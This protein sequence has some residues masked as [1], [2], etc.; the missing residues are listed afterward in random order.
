MADTSMKPMGSMAITT[1]AHIEYRISYHLQ[2]AYNEIL[3]VGR[4]LNEAKD[5]GLVPHG[6]WEEWVRTTTNMSERQAQKLMQAARSIQAGS[7]MENLSISKIQ[8]ILALPEPEREEVAEK[9]QAEDMSL[10]E[11]QLEVAKR[12]ATQDKLHKVE[13]DLSTYTKQT[14]KEREQ[15][16]AEIK[17]LQ[18]IPIG[19]PESYGISPE[20]QARI[21]R[22]TAELEE[23]EAYAEAQAGLRQ[24]A[25]QQLLEAQSQAA[26][27]GVLRGSTDTR[28]SVED[29]AAAVRSFIGTAGMLPHMGETLRSAPELERQQYRQYIEMLAAWVEGA[30]NAMQEVDTYY[31]VR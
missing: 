31:D 22:L 14:R 28:L 25:Q 29:V 5:A 27:G 23:A 10:R 21:D 9:A 12:K 1:L 19:K 16:L 20:V 24:K 6:Q 15:L 4:C 17:R 11:L 13:A 3:A 26:R 8:A 18:A 7:A 30:K 2:G